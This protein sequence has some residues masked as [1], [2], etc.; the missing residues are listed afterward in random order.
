MQGSQILRASVSRFIVLEEVLVAFNL[1]T[2]AVLKTVNISRC[3]T[4]PLAV[5]M[6]DS[7]LRAGN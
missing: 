3:R 1:M 7:F 6:N 2:F 5:R 4:L